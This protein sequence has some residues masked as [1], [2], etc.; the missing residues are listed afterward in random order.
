[1]AGKASTGERG[2]RFLEAGGRETEAGR[3]YSSL[4]ES[5]FRFFEAKDL[6]RV[7]SPFD[8]FSAD[9]FFV[10]KTIPSL[11]SVLAFF[12]ASSSCASLLPSSF[13]S[14]DFSSPGCFRLKSFSTAPMIRVIR[15]HDVPA[16]PFS[17]SASTSSFDK[18]PERRTT[19]V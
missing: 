5:K 10:V 15:G 17:T 16:V 2:G 6:L 12:V 18:S 14:S 8:L 4:K 19:T 1:M 9:F 7:S 13:D 3:N 11:L